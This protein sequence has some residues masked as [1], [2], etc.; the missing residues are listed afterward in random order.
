MIEAG[1]YTFPLLSHCLVTRFG[2]NYSPSTRF[3][4][5]V[6]LIMHFPTLL[7]A[8]LAGL[9]LAAPPQYGPGRPNTSRRGPPQSSTTTS[10]VTK[11]ATTRGLWNT[12]TTW[13]TTYT[14]CTVTST[15][16]VTTTSTPGQLTETETE[17]ETET[18]TAD[19]ITSSK[20]PYVSSSLSQQSRSPLSLPSFLIRRSWH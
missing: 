17:T 2:R 19:T 3:T 20:L 15:T 6:I 7:V 18:S 9:T 5:V 8:S 4:L 10:C 11:M 1:P 14:P 16:T 12:Q 13:T